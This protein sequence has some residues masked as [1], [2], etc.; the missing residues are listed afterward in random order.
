MSLSRSGD[1]PARLLAALEEWASGQVAHDVAVAL[2]VEGAGLVRE[3]FRASKAPDGQ[4]W[5]PL[6]APRDGRPWV[7]RQPLRKTGRLE[8]TATRYTVDRSGFVMTS[9]E[10]GAYHQ[11]EEPRTRLPRRPFYP[12]ESGLSVGWEIALSAAADDAVREHLP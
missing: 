11:S 6:A 7:P 12:D 3:G 10:Y 5:R 8:Y 9:T 4:R 1:D 2:A